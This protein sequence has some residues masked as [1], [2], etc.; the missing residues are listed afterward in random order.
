MNDLP[1][2]T[3]KADEEIAALKQRIAELERE[4]DVVACQLLYGSDNSSATMKLMEKALAKRD[5]AQ[6]IKAIDE[7]KGNVN[8]Y[9]A[10][11]TN[12]MIA[13]ECVTVEEI[14]AYHWSLKEQLRKAGE[15]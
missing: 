12:K 1:L 4:R 5:L 9:M 15:A 2:F 13:R 10:F 14:D 3:R 8:I 6:Q 11:P 7:L